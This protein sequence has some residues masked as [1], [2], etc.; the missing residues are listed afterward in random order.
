M[1]VKNSNSVAKSKFKEALGILLVLVAASALIW[2]LLQL[3]GCNS[4]DEPHKAQKE[5]AKVTDT[6]TGLTYVECPAGYG[7]DNVKDVYMEC[8]DPDDKSK[9]LQFYELAFADADKYLALK[10]SNGYTLYREESVK[11]PSIE[12]FGTGT[13]KI[14]K[15]GTIR[16]W[17]YLYSTEAVKG[18]KEADGSE[19]IAMIIEALSGKGVESATGD[20]SEKYHYSIWLTS[21]ECQGLYYKVEFRVDENGA[22]YLYDNVTEKLVKAPKELVARFIA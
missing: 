5:W 13:A 21:K 15:A 20:W 7:P 22:E 1:S 8:A 19:Y 17:D 16:P 10:T 11:A 6:K 4:E 3:R 12:N 14:F 18:D 9:K 2:G